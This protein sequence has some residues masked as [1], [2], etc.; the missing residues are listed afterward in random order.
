[1]IQ[2][3]F[4]VETASA[5]SERI[6]DR[7]YEKG[8]STT[9]CAKSSRGDRGAAR[10]RRQAPR[11]RAGRKPHVVLVVGVNGT[12][13][14]TTIGKIAAGLTRSGRK[15]MLAAG[16]TFR[17]AAIEQLKIWAAAPRGGDRPRRRIGRREL[18]FEAMDEAKAA[19]TDVL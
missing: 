16:D 18:A 7:R 2:A 9:R 8:I 10:P 19:G 12:G 17:A 3:I 11:H 5:I 1:M 6:S 14:T 4:G 13:K 15:V